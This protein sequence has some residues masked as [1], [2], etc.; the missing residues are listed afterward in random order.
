MMKIELIVIMLALAGCI[1]P[2]AVTDGNRTDALKPV[3]YKI[4]Q[5]LGDSKYVFCDEDC[6]VHSAKQFEVDDQSVN[7]PVMLL[8][9]AHPAS[10]MKALTK[11]FK[12]HFNFDSHALT[13]S[14]KTEVAAILTFLETNGSKH[15]T[16]V[17]KTD[18]VGTKGYNQRLAKRRAECVKQALLR[19]QLAHKLQLDV[20]TNCCVINGGNYKEAR[21]TDVTILVE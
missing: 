21:R 12:V 14:S 8:K 7:R 11:E 20:S 4:T 6:S 13:K 5:Q 1:S 17:G 16:I 10:E 18:P 2:R 3:E 19:D 9:P 15:I